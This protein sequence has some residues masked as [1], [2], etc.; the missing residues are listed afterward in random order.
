MDSSQVYTPELVKETFFTNMDQIL[1][2]WMK[3]WSSLNKYEKNIV[4]ILVE[5]D[6]LTWGDL[7]EKTKGSRGT[8]NKYLTNLKNKGILAFINRKY[9][10]DDEMLKIWLIHEKEVYGIYPL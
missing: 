5:E 7:F 6:S 2:M 3:V 9:E 8:F 10:I 1:M 4:K